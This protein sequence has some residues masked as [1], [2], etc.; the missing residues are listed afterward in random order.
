MARGGG[1]TTFWLSSSGILETEFILQREASMNEMESMKRIRSEAA[2]AANADDAGVWRWFSALLEERRI[3]WR[4][5]FDSWVVHVDRT[6]VASELTFYDAIR[7]AKRAVDHR[8][9]QALGRRRMH[10][11]RERHDSRSVGHRV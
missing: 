1:V 10:Q 7:A 2:A 6:R 4:Y 11:A 3:R 9:V 8:E 5:M